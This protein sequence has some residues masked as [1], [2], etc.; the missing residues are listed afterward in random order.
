MN[1]GKQHR[2]KKI[3]RW[4]GTV[5]LSVALIHVAACN[6]KQQPAAEADNTPEHMVTIEAAPAASIPPPPVRNSGDDW[7]QQRVRESVERTR[8]MSKAK[9]GDPPKLA[10]PGDLSAPPESTGNLDQP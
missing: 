2:Q 10:Q 7:F 1:T 8:A 9:L 4:A 6:G 5:A 3:T